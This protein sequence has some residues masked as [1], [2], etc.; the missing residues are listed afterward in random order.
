VTHAETDA[1]PEEYAHEPA[2]A[3]VRRRRPGS[4][5]GNSAR[6]TGAS[7]EHGLLICEVGES[8]HHLVKLLPEV[9]FAWVEFKVGQMGYSSSSARTSWRIM[10]GSRRWPRRGVRASMGSDSNGAYFSQNVGGLAFFA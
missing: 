6:R 7:V 1:L 9:P 10:T 8:E 2:L 4:G 5:A 3:C